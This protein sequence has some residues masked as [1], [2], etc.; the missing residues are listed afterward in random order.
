MKKLQ[1]LSLGVATLFALAPGLLP[2]QEVDCRMVAANVRSM[3]QKGP[4][5]TLTVVEDA[6]VAAPGCV[7]EI[8]GSAIDASNAD[9]PLVQKIVY[10][11]VKTTQQHAPIIAECAVAAA[12]QHADFVRAA[13]AEAFEDA[14]KT[15]KK[16]VQVAEAPRQ[17]MPSQPEVAPQQSQ[18][19]PAAAPAPVAVAPAPEQKAR[20]R[21]PFWNS[22]PKTSPQPE[23]GYE[24]LSEYP[25]PD[26]EV[27]EV[28]VAQTSSG[29]EVVEFAP[30]YA[31]DA[32]G[33]IVE[34][35]MDLDLVEEPFDPETPYP[36]P[37]G[38]TFF[39]GPPIDMTGLYLVPPVASAPPFFDDDDPDEPRNRDRGVLSSVSK[40]PA[41]RVPNRPKRPRPPKPPVISRP[42]SPTGP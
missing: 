31:Y 13:F 10:T 26:T 42:I 36:F 5:H 19:K 40:P 24:L 12:P 20:S 21:F 2:A 23:Q 30:N 15:G 17:E 39:G 6:L 22:R 18:A 25:A 35:Q 3:I 9:G 7:C 8:V 27:R 28:V 33:V 34:P 16:P 38:I 37:P 32:K 29:K 41:V 11:A 1:I 4:E 14:P